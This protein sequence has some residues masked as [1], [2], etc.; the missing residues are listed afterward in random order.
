MVSPPLSLSASTFVQAS[1]ASTKRAGIH[2]QVAC[3]AP[4]SRG[5]DASHEGQLRPPRADCAGI[6]GL[7][8][9]WGRRT[10]ERIAFV[11][12][13]SLAFA[14][15]IGSLVDKHLPFL[16]SSLQDGRP[17]VCDCRYVAASPYRCALSF[18]AFEQCTNLR[19]T[20]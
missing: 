4:S 1:C 2:M 20:Q 16:T 18:V 7:I 15:L 19:E 14:L 8:R 6:I 9:R 3:G 5:V 10:E 17:P 13:H 12:L 11:Q